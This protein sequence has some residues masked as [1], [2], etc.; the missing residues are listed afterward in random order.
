MVGG[1]RIGLLD[2]RK[3]P[4]Y[5]SNHK[6]AIKAH[7]VKMLQ[8]H[9]QDTQCSAGA[10]ELLCNDDYGIS[11]SVASMSVSAMALNPTRR[12]KGPMF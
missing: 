4:A 8:K 10:G 12:N 9:F 11:F 6:M 5:V 2:V 7:G 1:V 3:A